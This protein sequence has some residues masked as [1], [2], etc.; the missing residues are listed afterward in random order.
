MKKTILS[1]LMCA[2]VYTNVAVAE[3]LTNENRTEENVK[4]DEFRHPVET[5]SFFGI[6]KNDKVVEILPG[7]GWYTEV[8]SPYLSEG[9]LVAAHYPIDTAKAYQAKLRAN[10]E[11]KIKD[12][13][14]FYDNVKVTDFKIGEDVSEEAKNADAV[15][16]FRALHGFQ[17][18]GDLAASFVEF[19]KMLKPN[20]VL[21]IVQHEAPE[22]YSVIESS[23]KGYLPK[24]HVISVAEAAGFVLE[25]ESYINNNSKDKI[26]QDNIKRGVWALAP[27]FA[28]EELKEELKDVGES[29]RMTLLFRLK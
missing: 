8:L 18:S 2:S 21:G 19:K 27:S 14:G 24:S 29:N 5:L 7:S 11:I 23:K 26:L 3:P 6:E 28:V 17:N 12:T 13:K 15:V 9:Q 22:G 1:I 16:V 20:G 25:S 4:R 10:Y